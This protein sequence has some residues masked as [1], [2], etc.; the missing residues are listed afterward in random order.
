MRWSSTL[1]L[2]SPRKA[3]RAATVRT[4]LRR[5]RR[6]AGILTPFLT[7]DPR[8]HRERRRHGQ[9]RQQAALGSIIATA[10]KR[11]HAPVQRVA[12]QA[13]CK[14]AEVRSEQGQG[15]VPAEVQ[16]DGEPQRSTAPAG[17]A[18]QDAPGERVEDA[19]YGRVPVAH[20][21]D[22]EDGGDGQDGGEGSH[23]REQKL[24]GV[25]VKQHLLS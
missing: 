8:Y 17:I 5:T 19:E 9:G 13:H 22:A 18:E 16:A 12:S 25:A 21:R 24:E 11:T 4:A 15:E 3:A 23:G 7:T 2:E 6:G 20:V 1:F 10:P 14:P